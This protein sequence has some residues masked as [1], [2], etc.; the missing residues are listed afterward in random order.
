MIQFIELLFLILRISSTYEWCIDNGINQPSFDEWRSGA[1]FDP[2]IVRSTNS[3]SD[4]GEIITRGFNNRGLGFYILEAKM[5]GL[6]HLQ[7][8]K[9]G[10]FKYVVDLMGTITSRNSAHYTIFCHV[11]E[12]V[13]YLFF[14]GKGAT[15]NA[16]PSLLSEK[17]FLAR[18]SFYKAVVIY[19]QELITQGTIFRRFNVRDFYFRESKIQNLMLTNF[20]ELISKE[21]AER[22]LI[23]FEWNKIPAS[24][25]DLLTPL[26][27][28]QR[29]SALEVICSQNIISIIEKLETMA[30]VK[31]LTHRIENFE[32]DL[33]YVDFRDFINQNNGFTEMQTASLKKI[34]LKLITL[35][36]SLE[37]TPI[38]RLRQNLSPER[39]RSQSFED[40]LLRYRGG[41]KSSR[42]IIHPATHQE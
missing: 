9:R 42:N 21:D 27:E 39:L 19:L 2:Q 15:K 29:L 18:V 36:D 38:P 32:K 23:Y 3:E 14:A 26:S 31:P 10:T 12:E 7:K 35:S 6:P 28:Q 17:T 34:K 22:I 24:S 5:K 37:R 25:L 4:L 41:R 40:T 33:R 16:N 20:H 1:G 30:R 13:Q 11:K 8:S